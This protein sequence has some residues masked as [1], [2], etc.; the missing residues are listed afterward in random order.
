MA[1]SGPLTSTTASSSDLKISEELVTLIRGFFATPVIASLG[2]L[3]FFEKALSETSF[4]EWNFE[5]VPNKMNLRFSFDYLSRLGF[6]QETPDRQYRLTELGKQIFQRL[7]SFLAPHSYGDYMRLFHEHLMD[8]KVRPVVDRLENIMG[9]GRTHERYFP[10]AVSHIRRKLSSGWI[11][12][13]GCGD[14]KFLGFVL[15][16][17]PSI[18]AIGV[19]LSDVSVQETRK[20]IEQ[21]F[22]GR[23]I[24]AFGCDAAD[25][26]AWSKKIQAISGHA[27]LVISMWFLLHEISRRDPQNVVRFLTEVHNF[28][29]HT[30]LIV[31]DLVRQS[32]ELLSRHRNKLVMPEYLL[33]HDI[34]GQGVLSWREYQ[35]ILKSIPYELMMQRT[36]DEIGE[37]NK[38]K[39]PATFVW[40][41]SP[42]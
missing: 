40:C 24:E 22:P 23:T 28:F 36:F 41:L 32:A 5:N 37:S 14:G 31:G 9:S 21:L 3:G 35:K 29:P 38:S 6:L 10:V 26:P 27:S 18:C 12:D 8:P 17:I 15:K 11:A 4:N 20:N 13:I 19:D 34:S 25:I 1:E 39:E 33:F 7:S 30:P 16:D 2:K 42:Q